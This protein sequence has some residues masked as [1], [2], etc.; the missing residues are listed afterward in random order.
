MNFDHLL[1][2]QFT[3]DENNQL[4]ALKTNRIITKINY[5]HVNPS[6]WW[7]IDAPWSRVGYRRASQATH[8]GLF[9]ITDSNNP[10][11]VIYDSFKNS[12]TT[13]PKHYDLHDTHFVKIRTTNFYFRFSIGK[14]NKTLHEEEQ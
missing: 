11:P 3:I 4:N 5:K 6:T 13:E 8:W 7:T 1:F 14:S 12:E 10:Y 9:D 2:A